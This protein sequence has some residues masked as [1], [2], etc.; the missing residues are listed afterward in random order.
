ML[1]KS[2]C[3]FLTFAIIMISTVGPTVESGIKQL[4]QA[5]V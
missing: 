2:T 5:L 4:N 1:L 3:I